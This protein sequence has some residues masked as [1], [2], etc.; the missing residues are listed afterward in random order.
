MGAA[1]M[2]GKRPNDAIAHQ[3]SRGPADNGPGNGITLDDP[4]KP[5][6]GPDGAKRQQIQTRGLASRSFRYFRGTL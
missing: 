4:A 5:L 1:V 6:N 2:A 3:G